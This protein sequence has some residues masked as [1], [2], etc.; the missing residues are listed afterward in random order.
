MGKLCRAAAGTVRFLSCSVFVCLSPSNSSVATSTQPSTLRI[1]S[2]AQQLLHRQPIF[3]CRVESFSSYP[4]KGF[5]FSFTEDVLSFRT[6][7]VERCTKQVFIPHCLIAAA[8]S[9]SAR[10]AEE[11][12]CFLTA[13]TT[14]GNRENRSQERKHG[15]RPKTC[16]QQE[17]KRTVNKK[18][19]ESPFHGVSARRKRRS[20]LRNRKKPK[21]TPGTLHSV[22]KKKKEE[23]RNSQRWDNKGMEVMH[24]ILLKKRHAFGGEKNLKKNRFESQTCESKHLLVRM[25]NI[26]PHLLFGPKPPVSHFEE[27]KTKCSRAPCA[28]VLCGRGKKAV[29]KINIT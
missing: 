2:A 4:T 15:K 7:E 27:S 23:Q 16:S 17:S 1:L 5:S 24:S 20:A 25:N 19:V 13:K 6:P 12:F 14:T 22:W 21:E 3:S 18:F 26:K 11:H 10:L 9:S 8:G 28:V 29:L